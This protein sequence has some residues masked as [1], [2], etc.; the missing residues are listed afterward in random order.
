[1]T[2]SLRCPF[3]QQAA[4]G[5]TLF[6]FGG[7]SRVFVCPGCYELLNTKRHQPYSHPMQRLRRLMGH[8]GKEVVIHES[9]PGHHAAPCD[10]QATVAQGPAQH[11]IVRAAESVSHVVSRTSLTH[12]GI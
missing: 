4:E 10:G 12:G 3:C 5:L 1:M 8:F 9:A 6:F 2:N 7:G 11:R